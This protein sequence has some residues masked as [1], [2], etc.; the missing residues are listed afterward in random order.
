MKPTLTSLA[1]AALLALAAVATAAAEPPRG[2]AP[3]SNSARPNE[4]DSLGSGWRQQQ[5]E[6]RELRRERRLIPMGKVIDMIHRLN[7]GPRSEQL[8]AGLEYMGDRPVYRV[9]WMT[10]NGRRV[11]Y[12]VDAVTGQVLSGG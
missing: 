12:I 6:V 9:R 7:P 1:G 10:N 5:D 2:K 4:P 8:D 3:A 11:D